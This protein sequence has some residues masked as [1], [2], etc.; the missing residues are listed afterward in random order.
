L[1]VYCRHQP[2][3]RAWRPF[4]SERCKMADLRRWL[5][6]G[7]SVPAEDLPEEPDSGQDGEAS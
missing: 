7:Y 5:T 4:C 6:G 2:A 1:C 3:D